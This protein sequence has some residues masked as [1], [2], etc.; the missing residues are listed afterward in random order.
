MGFSFLFHLNFELNTML[1]KIALNKLLVG[2][3]KMVVNMFLVRP[4]IRKRERRNDHTNNNNNNI[5]INLSNNNMVK[6]DKQEE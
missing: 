4:H 3:E 2:V 6:D 1:T 5:I